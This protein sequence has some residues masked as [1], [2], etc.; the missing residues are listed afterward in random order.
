MAILRQDEW[1]RYYVEVVAGDTLRGISVDYNVP[2]NDLMYWNGISNEN[3]I[4][5][6]QH[7]YIERISDNPLYDKSLKINDYVPD[8]KQFGLL[9]TSNNTLFASWE[10]GWRDTKSFKVR[11]EY[12]VAGWPHTWFVGDSSDIEYDEAF[13][14]SCK[15]SFY[16]IPSDADRVRFSVK[17]IAVGSKWTGEWSTLHIYDR[18]EGPPSTP[19]TPSIELNG[20]L[21]LT[22]LENLNLNATFIE[23]QVLKRNDSR[24]DQ[25]KISNTTIQYVDEN[26]AANRENGYARYSCYVDINGEYKV[27]AR[28]VRDGLYSDWSEY[29]SSVY[30]APV[31]P[32]GITTIRASS[33]TSVY[34]EWAA[35]D[36]AE[37]YDIQYATELAHFDDSNEPVTETGIENNH[38]T[39]TGLESGDEYFFRVRSVREDVASAWSEPASVIVGKK[40]G[41]PTTWSS[42]TTV[43]TGEPLIFYWVHNSEDGSS[44][45]EAELELTIGGTVETI[46]IANSGTDETK[47]KI[48]SLD[49]DTSAL[50]YG[51]VIL[52]RVRTKG[53][54]ADYSDWSIQRTVEVHARPSLTLSVTDS[55]GNDIGSLSA[56]P[57]HI[58]AT[59]GPITQIPIGY[60]I[61]I[62]ANESYETVD[63]FGDPKLVAKGEELF[64]R[65]YDISTALSIT[66]SAG[67]VSLE[68]NISYTLKGTVTMN[69]GLT[70]TASKTFTT[71]WARNVHS[72]NAEVILDTT[73]YTA[74][75]RPYCVDMDGAYVENITLSVYRRNFDG[76]FTELM[77][78]IP[79]NGATHITDP[80]PALD[81]ARYRV[82]AMST[83]TGEVVYY[84]MP[85]VYVGGSEIVLQWDEVWSNFDTP[86]THVPVEPSWTGSV[87]KLPYNIDIRE[88]AKPD[89]SHIEYIGRRYPVSY[90]GTQLGETA[91]WSTVIDKKDKDTLYALRRLAR[92]NGRVY[93]RE[94]SG[95]GYWATVIVSIDQKHKDLIIPVS[96]DVTRV[97]GGV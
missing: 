86:D 76:T 34:L 1:E 41:I 9:S 2:I 21:L 55:K 16:N 48:K 46:P 25:F 92:W 56:F 66:L 23:F 67:D 62:V 89:V 69:S 88:A 95:S 79:N 5:V 7:I 60:H 33:P 90:H 47:D 85:G 94:P 12:T 51:T 40:P 27:R 93:V 29:S 31:A 43:V 30:S 63:T 45:T 14:D 20:D 19:P 97:E 68:N 77:T 10:W 6:G 80:H 57:M 18:R 38:F 53:I 72:P 17:A 87:L 54:H 24:F 8:I 49:F 71:A 65:H 42:S 52:W 59:G 61:S 39:I 81:Y 64:S 37:T 28:A 35:V 22:K 15:Q 13:P 44:E 70:A 96:L 75:L 32:A 36:N 84:D 50:S 3:A 83:V 78:G 91:T 74:T 11:W 4:V 26:D 82:V 73:S 58:H